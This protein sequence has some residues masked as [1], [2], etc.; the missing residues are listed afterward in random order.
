MQ[1]DVGKT[2]RE[3]AIRWYP[4]HGVTKLD[5][6]LL[7]HGHADAILGLD[8]LRG[9]QVLAH[10]HL[11]AAICGKST[12]SGEHATVPSAHAWIAGD[13]KH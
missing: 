10:C 12:V 9:L 2:F 13:P 4:K 7:T 6:V 1:I 5:A 8:D 11:C 3:N